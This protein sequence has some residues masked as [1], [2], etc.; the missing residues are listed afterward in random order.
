MILETTSKEIKQKKESPAP[1]KD[2]NNYKTR[3]KIVL[4]YKIIHHRFH[5]AFINFPWL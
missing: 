4:Y 5:I 1:I 2:L 3:A